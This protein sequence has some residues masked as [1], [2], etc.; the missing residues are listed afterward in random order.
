MTDHF[1]GQRYGDGTPGS[2][3]ELAAEIVNRFHALYYQGVDGDPVWAHTFWMG[4][5]VAKCPLDL[6]IYQEIL[7]DTRPTL[8]IETGTSHGGS[9][10]YFAHIF[11]QLGQGR[12]ISIDIEK[13]PRPQHPRISYLLGS[14]A[15]TDIADQVRSFLKPGDR[16]M[17]VLDSDHSAQHVSRELALFAPLVSIGC[18]LVVED[19]N[20]NGRPVEPQFGP[21]PY[22][23]VEEFLSHSSN[24]VTDLAREKFMVTFNPDGWL[25]RIS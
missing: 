10:F 12:V 23:A 1:G 5:P 15:S 16:V 19:S 9:A 6:W 2:L 13:M 22:E 14:S 11:D 7:Y 25:K 8:L 24:F 4:V 18:Y 3:K 20:V 21:G 17:V